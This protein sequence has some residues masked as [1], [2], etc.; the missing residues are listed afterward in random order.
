MY[1]E[2]DHDIFSVKDF[3]MNA[4]HIVE[5]QSYGEATTGENATEWKL[6]IQRELES[7]KENDT[8]NV[9]SKKPDD[10]IVKNK[11][12]FKVKYNPD[13]S[14][15]R[16]KAR[17]VAKGYSQVKGIDYSETFAPV[18]KIVSVRMLL[19]IAISKGQHMLNPPKKTPSRNA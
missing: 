1:E 11:W 8:W 18:I 7:L 16:F 2:V 12:V 6:A 10:N 13:G 9:V 4:N 19:T 15:E 14:I 17:L 3:V 5:P